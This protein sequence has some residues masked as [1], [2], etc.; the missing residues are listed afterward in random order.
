MSDGGSDSTAGL[1][2]LRPLQI[3]NEA[4][5][6]AAHAELEREGMHFLLDWSPEEPWSSYV[7]R[8]HRAR[9]GQDLPPGWVPS[10]FL[11][12]EVGCELVGRTS[13]RH[14]LNDYLADLGGHI[15][16][17]VRPAHRGRGHAREILRQSLVIARAE[18]VERILV[19]CDDDNIASR[20]TIER[21]G[22]VLEDVRSG[23]VPS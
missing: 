13:I 6:R 2:R 20:R 16:Y 22:G 12:A 11:V 8:L 19:T 14:E 15:G 23:P 5:A 3:D 4:S 10:T 1:L 21:L 7:V 18:G 17:A 9:H